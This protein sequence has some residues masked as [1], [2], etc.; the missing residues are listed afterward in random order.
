[1]RFRT[2]FISILGSVFFSSG[3]LLGLI[4][5]GLYF[6]GELEA[7][8]LIPRTGEM[9]LKTLQCP[10][11]ITSTESGIVSAAFNNP[12][13]EEI[14]PNIRAFISHLN[15]E[16][17]ESTILTLV[18]GEVRNLQWTVSLDDMVFG[19]LILVNLY[20][21]PYNDF[22]SHQASCGILVSKI[23]GISGKQAFVLT[24]V[25]CLLFIGVGAALWIYGNSPLRGL[26][27]NLT[28]ANCALAVIVLAGLASILPRWWGL[29]GFFT[30]VAL[31]LIVIIITEF[32]L[33]P[34]AANYT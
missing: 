3:I 30:F 9:G 15:M 16:R 4:L 5:C 6:W 18:P 14:K 28:E 11:M 1:M 22:P 21:G 20:E 25:T 32:V 33:F 17:M 29:I 27:R 8:L 31:L 7:T 13:R 24:L 34:S 19:R 10:M 23:P 26:K 2:K 12:T